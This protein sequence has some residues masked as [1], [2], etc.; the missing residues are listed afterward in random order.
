M[1]IAFKIYRKDNKLSKLILVGDYSNQLKEKWKSIDL[2]EGVILTGKVQ[3]SELYRLL[4][5]SSVLIHPSEEET[6]G[7]TLL[8]GMA[9]RL[10]CVGGKDSGAVPH[11]LGNGLYGIL[12]NIYD[13]NSIA[14]AMKKTE[15]IE[16][17]SKIIQRS[18]EY[19]I[20]TYSNNV[21]AT[22]HVELYKTYIKDYN[23]RKNI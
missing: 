17:T 16:F 22:T 21:V 11:V 14:M 19:L 3:R 6:F 9:R 18:T 8:E 23:D 20:K 12:F 1:L 15:D 5:N 2:L 4:D 13:V 7:N 10:P